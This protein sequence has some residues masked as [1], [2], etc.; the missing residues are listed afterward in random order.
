VNALLYEDFR[1]EQLGKNPVGHP[2][3]GP[4]VKTWVQDWVPTQAN[5]PNQTGTLF[6]G[7]LENRGGLS[8]VVKGG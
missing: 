3:I 5:I 2:T 4:H 7:A 8:K 1:Q 6:P